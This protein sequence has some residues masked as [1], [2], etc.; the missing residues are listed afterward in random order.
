[1]D[2]LAACRETWE[3]DVASLLIRT[4]SCDGDHGTRAMQT[5][6]QTWFDRLQALY[7]EE[8]RHYHTFA[9]ICDMLQ[10]FEE[11]KGSMSDPVTVC[12][13]IFFHDA[14]Y[15]P[16][17][18]TNEEDSAELFSEFA[19]ELTRQFPN[20]E[21]VVKRSVV[22]DYILQTKKHDVSTSSDEDLKLFIDIDMSILAAERTRYEAYCRAIRR[23]YIHVDTETFCRARAA[24]LRST[25]LNEGSKNVFA[26]DI[27][28]SKVYEGGLDCEAAVKANI[29]WECGILERGELP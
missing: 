22:V 24:F 2:H 21:N 12:L 23:E 5:M 19:N 20:C 3:R 15:N 8:A 6:L 25:T 16:K 13:A 29:A 17:S 1:M 11:H 10:Q 26:S 27:F 18:S 4:C 7:S 9:H 28:K 14:I